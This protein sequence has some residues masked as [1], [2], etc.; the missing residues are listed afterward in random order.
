M[1]VVWCC[2]G[3]F[4]MMVIGCGD[5]RMVPK[6]V[7]LGF[8]KISWCLWLNDLVRRFRYRYSYR[9][10]TFEESYP[11]SAEEGELSRFDFGV[12]LGRIFG[13]ILLVFS[14]LRTNLSVTTQSLNLPRF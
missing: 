8:W 13:S 7:G 11:P 14:F 6:C 12:A 5:L 2:S 1:A 4:L 9:R 3:E 10:L